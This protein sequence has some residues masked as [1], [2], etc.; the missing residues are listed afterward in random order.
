[1]KTDR[2]ISDPIRSES[3]RNEDMVGVFRNPADADADMVFLKSDGCGL[4]DFSIGL[5]DRTFAG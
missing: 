4:S 3:V 1:V 2:I 5:S